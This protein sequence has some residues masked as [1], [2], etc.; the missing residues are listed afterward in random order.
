MKVGPQQSDTLATSIMSQVEEMATRNFG[1]AAA[2][3]E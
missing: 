3:H 1:S 2:P